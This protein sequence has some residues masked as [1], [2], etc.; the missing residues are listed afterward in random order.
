MILPYHRL[1]DAARE[2]ALGD[3]KIGTTLRGIGPAYESLAARRAIRVAELYRPATLAA[4][5]KAIADETGAFLRA[6]GVKDVPT[7]DAVLSML[8]PLAERLRP[9][10]TGTPAVT[11]ATS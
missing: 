9:H 5:V 10:V 11:C 4:R 2:N 8:G 1:L 7:A 6:L 3:A